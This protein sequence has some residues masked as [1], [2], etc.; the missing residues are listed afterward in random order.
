MGSCIAFPSTGHYP[1][2]MPG[3]SSDPTRPQRILIVRLGAIGDVVNALTLASALKRQNP[4]AHL[5][6]LIHPLSEPLVRDNPCVDTVHKLARKGMMRALPAL[7]RELHQQRYDLVI[8][9]QRM[10]KSAVLAR[11]AGAPR[12]LGYDRGRC[13]EGAWM[14][15]GERIPGGPPRNHMVDQYAEFASYLGCTG[16]VSHPLPPISDENQARAK[17]WLS[18]LG[19]N[20]VVVHI[21][22][23]KPENRWAPERYADLIEGLLEGQEAGVV[24]TGGPGDVED[25]APT[26]ER[27]AGHPRFVDLL[28]QTSL[29]E[30][31]TVFSHCA[32][33]IGC[34]TGPMHLASALGLPVIALFGPADPLRTGP[35]GPQHRVIRDP[36][37][38]AGAPLPPASIDSVS[39]QDILFAMANSNPPE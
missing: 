5:G 12:V 19:P 27:L 13:K 31:M 37:A 33:F 24:L 2:F 14:L 18:G 11:L 32:Q 26:R 17:G 34:D 23:S 15:Y 6:W 36:A 3:K 16:P 25:A 1:P 38:I 35:Y 21:G 30:L 7:R 20:P 10:L 29:P 9:L 39:V 22:A 28:G 8:D 4:D